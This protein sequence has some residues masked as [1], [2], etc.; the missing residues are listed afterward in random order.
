QNYP[1]PF[2]PSTAI[3]FSVPQD[4]MVSLSVY[5]LLGRTVATLVDRPM[6]SGT[7]EQTFHAGA[8]AS[9]TYLYALRITSPE[10]GAVLHSSVRKMLLLK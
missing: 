10:N 7:Y 9:G 5:D 1:N 4:A 3:R 6:M 2:N 8:L